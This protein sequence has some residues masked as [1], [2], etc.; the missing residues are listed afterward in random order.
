[1]E[2]PFEYIGADITFEI[3]DG[4]RKKKV[5]TA[6]STKLKLFTDCMREKGAVF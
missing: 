5:K 2:N 6:V 4:I 1:M 3:E